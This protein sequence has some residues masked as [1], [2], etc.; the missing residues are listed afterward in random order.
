MSILACNS[1][2]RDYLD[3]R[4]A[5][6]GQEAARDFPPLPTGLM[7]TKSQPREVPLGL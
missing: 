7:I 1:H 3:T 4:C 5:G 6:P 2:R